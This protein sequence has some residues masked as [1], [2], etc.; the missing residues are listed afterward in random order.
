MIDN[1]ASSVLP[2]CVAIPS[3]ARGFFDQNGMDK[4]SVP[5]TGGTP[6]SAKTP[7]SVRPA[8]TTPRDNAMSTHGPEHS[9]PTSQ[10]LTPDKSQSDDG[11]YESDG[12]KLSGMDMID[13]ANSGRPVLSSTADLGL[14]EQHQEEKSGR[15]EPGKE[16]QKT[17]VVPN[18]IPTPTSPIL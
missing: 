12:E 8:A 15:L 18:S 5:G 13:R 3:R 14:R 4:P 16:L 9:R 17:D 7:A 6:P 11:E 2:S 1:Q 10:N